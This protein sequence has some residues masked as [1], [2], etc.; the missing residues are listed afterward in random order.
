MPIDNAL[1]FDAIAV[2]EL[3]PT[4]YRCRHRSTDSVI[5]DF[6]V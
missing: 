3:I 2:R 4:G 1:V 6:G 5:Y